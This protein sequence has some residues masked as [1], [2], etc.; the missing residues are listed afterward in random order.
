MIALAQR[1]QDALSQES[2]LFRIGGDEFVLMLTSIDEQHIYAQNN[3][4]LKALERPLHIDGVTVDIQYSAGVSRYH[5][6]ELED[7][8][9]VA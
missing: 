2:T 9:R 7:L 6:Q 1:L 3:V 4:L 5:G 8:C